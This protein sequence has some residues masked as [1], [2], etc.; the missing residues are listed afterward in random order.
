MRVP[1]PHRPSTLS[2]NGSQ[3]RA[4]LLF[5]HKKWDPDRPTGPPSTQMWAIRSRS[6]YMPRTWEP[7]CPRTGE[8]AGVEL[9]RGV[10]T[11]SAEGWA[12]EG[13]VVVDSGADRRLKVCRL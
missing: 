6:L 4:V 3:R 11:R 9:L 7:C 12:A 2:M 8:R 13:L 10:L 5:T 1:Q